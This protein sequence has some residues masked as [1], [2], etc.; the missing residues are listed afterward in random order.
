[1]HS[2]RVPNTQLL[3]V[4]ADAANPAEAA[5]LA[6]AVADAA[7]PLAILFGEL[8]ST[9]APAARTR[10]LALFAVQVEGVP[11]LYAEEALWICGSALR[12]H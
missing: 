11:E 8:A 9:H 5:A 6:N 4:T 7:A 2:A 10:R 3:R 1:M 12:S